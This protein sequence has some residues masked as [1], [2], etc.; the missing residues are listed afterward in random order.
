MMFLTNLKI[1]VISTCL[2]NVSGPILAGEWCIVKDVFVFQ[3]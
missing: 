1:I 3:V 2:L